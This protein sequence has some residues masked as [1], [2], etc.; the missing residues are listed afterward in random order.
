MGAGRWWASHPTSLLPRQLFLR[1]GAMASPLL[2][3]ILAG[4]A[5]TLLRH[6]ALK[7]QNDA[8]CQGTCCQMA[9]RGLVGQGPPLPGGTGTAQWG[10]LLLNLS[11]AGSTSDLSDRYPRPAACLQQ[12]PPRP[13]AQAATSP[14]REAG[15]SR[16]GHWRRMRAALAGFT[17]TFAD[18]TWPLCLPSTPAWTL[19]PLTPPQVPC[20]PAGPA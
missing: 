1:A 2:V 5:P 11:S 18:L 9:L 3:V 7:A 12:P 13:P 8:G 17:H 16:G 10:L 6:I 19:C 20:L 15:R 14:P 4:V